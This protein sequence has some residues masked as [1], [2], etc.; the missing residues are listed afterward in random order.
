VVVGGLVVSTVFTLFLVPVILSVVFDLRPP[1][2]SDVPE[3]HEVAV[4]VVPNG[5]VL[6]MAHQPTE[7]STFDSSS[8]TRNAV[9]GGV[10]GPPTERGR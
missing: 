10:S 9:G 8:M 7:P 2:R 6:I 5:Q 3:A 4:A 1:R